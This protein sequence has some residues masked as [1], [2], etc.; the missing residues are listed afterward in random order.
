MDGVFQRQLSAAASA[1][2][3]TSRDWIIVGVKNTRK[4]NVLAR[5][6][7]GQ[8]ARYPVLWPAGPARPMNAENRLGHDEILALVLRRADDGRDRPALPVFSPPH[9]EARAPLY[10]DDHR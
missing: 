5:D 7:A 1:N 9:D 4:N 6:H 2:V 10:G 3:A 8:D